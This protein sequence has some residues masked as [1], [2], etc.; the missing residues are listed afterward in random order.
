MMFGWSLPPVVCRRALIYLISI[1]L[2]IVVL[3]TYC[4]VFFVL[5]SSCVPNVAIF[6]GLSILDCPFSFSNIYLVKCTLFH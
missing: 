6:S 4:V 2:H 5:S 3:N 1:C